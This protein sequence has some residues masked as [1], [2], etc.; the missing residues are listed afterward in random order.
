VPSQYYCDNDS[1]GHYTTTTY[2]FC[3]GP[4]R[5][6][7]AG[8]DCNDACATCY[9]GSTAYTTSVDGLD[10]DCDAQID[11]VI[12]F[13]CTPILGAAV[14]YACNSTNNWGPAE[15]TYPYRYSWSSVCPQDTTHCVKSG[16]SCTSYSGGWANCYIYGTVN[17]P[18]DQGGGT[19]DCSGITFYWYYSGGSGTGYHFY[20][21]PLTGCTQVNQYQ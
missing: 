11:E 10:Q 19:K 6:S 20:C 18:Y 13:I 14:S 15:G 7:P 3:T 12:D 2:L 5:T 8:D 21:S 9:P 1:D 4:S 16:S 17:R